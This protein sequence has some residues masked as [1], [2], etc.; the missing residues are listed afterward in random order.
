MNRS[1]FNFMLVLLAWH[2]HMARWW[3]PNTKRSEQCAPVAQ[4]HNS[5]SAVQQLW[6]S[7]WM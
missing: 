3:H 7:G 4:D 6:L 2:D 5:N 1:R